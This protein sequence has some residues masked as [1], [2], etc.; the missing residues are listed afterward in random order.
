MQYGTPIIVE[1]LPLG[2][3]RQSDERNIINNLQ[4]QHQAND[5]LFSAAQKGFDKAPPRSNEQN[6]SKEKDTLEEGEG[7]VDKGP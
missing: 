4:Y 2:L 3:V 7:I 5:F 1:T 6:D